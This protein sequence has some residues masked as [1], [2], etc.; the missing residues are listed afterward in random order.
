MRQKLS[1]EGEVAKILSEEQEPCSHHGKMGGGGKKEEH[2]TYRTFNRRYATVALD[3]HTLS[4]CLPQLMD[5][6]VRS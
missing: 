3:W 4:A 5:Q 6:K 2:G 1:K